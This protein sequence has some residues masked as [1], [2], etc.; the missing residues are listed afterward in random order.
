MFIC[1]LVDASHKRLCCLVMLL[2]SRNQEASRI[3]I[4]RRACVLMGL[5][6]KVRHDNALHSD[7][8]GLHVLVRVQAPSTWTLL[9]ETDGRRQRVFRRLKSQSRRL[10]VVHG[11]REAVV[12][13]RKYRR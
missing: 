4:T 12:H 3:G 10:Q 2:C 11:H 5:M 6:G 1:G 9:Q 13:K 7:R 8:V